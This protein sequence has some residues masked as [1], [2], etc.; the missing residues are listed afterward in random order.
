[1]NKSLFE[2]RYCAFLDV[3][4]FS[5]SVYSAFR[6]RSSQ[7]REE[8]TARLIELYSQLTREAETLD[9]QIHYSQFSDSIFLSMPSHLEDAAGQIFRVVERISTALLARGFLVRGAV[10]RGQVYAQDGMIFGPALIDAYKL[11]SQVA[12]HPMII[13][14]RS[15]KQSLTEPGDAMSKLLTSVDGPYYLNC[16][17]IFEKVANSTAEGLE[18]DPII[19]ERI[20]H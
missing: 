16:L 13:V 8:E 9:K 2:E 18:R 5:Q 6:E 14:S 17:G 3:L 20:L 12:S 19:L 7:K 15:V 11:E 4:G 1:M 10:V